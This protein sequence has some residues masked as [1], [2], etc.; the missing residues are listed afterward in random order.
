MKILLL[1][2]VA[3]PALWDYLNRSL[4]EGI[5]LVL[6]CGDLPAEYLDW[7]RMPLGYSDAPELL[8]FYGIFNEKAGNGFF[9][10]KG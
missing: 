3:D 8:T 6:A 4:L 10:T 1:S 7:I 5:E 9:E 2:D